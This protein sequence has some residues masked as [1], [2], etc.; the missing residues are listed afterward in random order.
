MSEKPETKATD[1]PQEPRLRRLMELIADLQE[2]ACLREME[3]LL[4]QGMSPQDLLGCF[5][6]GMRRVGQLF[7]QGAYFI[8]ALIMAGEI[9]RQ[10]TERLSPM[11]IEHPSGCGGGKVVIGTIQGDIHDLGKNL[12]AMMLRCHRFEVIDLGV[13]VPPQVFLDQIRIH[14]PD[15]VAM[16]CVLTTSVPMLKQVLDLVHAEPESIKPPVLVG[17]TCLDAV[18]AEHVGADYWAPDV[19]SGLRLCQRLALAMEEK[20]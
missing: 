7:E 14:R 18:L 17:G 16:S 12:F 2:D 8:A 5:M 1:L 3:S 4:T 19:A 10:A 11:L 20:T 13:D 9:M 6:E 15:V